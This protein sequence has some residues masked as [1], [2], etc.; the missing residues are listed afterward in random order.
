MC[1]LPLKCGQLMSLGENWLL[2]SASHNC[3]WI[4]GQGKGFYGETSGAPRREP[5]NIPLGE[6]SLKPAPDDSPFYS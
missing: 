5:T 6:Y 2:P 4:L 3:Q 1:G